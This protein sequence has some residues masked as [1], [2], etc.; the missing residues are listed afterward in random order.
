M[1]G[2]GEGDASSPPPPV[3]HEAP[4]GQ[5]RIADQRGKRAGKVRM[6]R[7][8]ATGPESAAKREI[9]GLGNVRQALSRRKAAHD[10]VDPQGRIDAVEEVAKSADARRKHLQWQL[11][12]LSGSVLRKRRDA[13]AEAR[14][15][16][17]ELRDAYAELSLIERGIPFLSFA[18]VES[19]AFAAAVFD[20]FAL[21]HP[22]EASGIAS[23]GAQRLLIGAVAAGVWGAVNGAG[24]A[25]AML[26]LG[27]P[28]RD[29][30][31]LVLVGIV[32][33]LGL[34]FAGFALLGVLRHVWTNDVNTAL[35]RSVE[36]KATVQPRLDAS[37]LTPMQAAAALA[38]SM[39][40]AIYAM[41]SDGRL[42][43][44]AITRKE[45][46]L[47][48]RE[49]DLLHT[50][51][52]I[53]ESVPKQIGNATIAPHEARADAKRAR[54]EMRGIDQQ[55]DADLEAERALT[56]A[57][58]GRHDARFEEEDK[59]HG[60]GGSALTRHPDGLFRRLLRSKVVDEAPAPAAHANGNG[61]GKH[62]KG[63]RLSRDEIGR[64]VAGADAGPRA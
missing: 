56:R 28:T 60:N 27:L 15:R 5:A 3:G 14:N 34:L 7:E 55:L 42:L 6:A 40:V 47:E 4:H 63:R 19:V 35:Q 17:Q 33:I 21:A 64:L 51:G 41:G 61:N 50:L 48:A 44:R 23:A 12:H 37:F 43:R 2:A 49:A 25:S 62:R 30:R 58:E 57:A 1:W 36:G 31:K 16:L 9:R 53:E 45:E 13:I 20:A 22:L 11:S 39:L 24:Y 46:E 59:L 8:R 10:R 38:G 26:A 32:G 54:A 18:L 29:R 52:Q